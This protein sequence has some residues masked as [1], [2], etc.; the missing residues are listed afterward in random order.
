M[1]RKSE[2]ESEGERKG[3]T[4]RKS[5]GATDRVR[6]YKLNPEDNKTFRQLIK[7]GGLTHMGDYVR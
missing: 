2:G 6:E 4:V 1:V 5:E 3:E 7:S